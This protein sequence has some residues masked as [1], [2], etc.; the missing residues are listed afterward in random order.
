MASFLEVELFPH[1][2]PQMYSI[3]HF[4]NDNLNETKIGENKCQKGLDLWKKEAC[5]WFKARDVF[6]SW[7]KSLPNSETTTIKIKYRSSYFETHC[8]SDRIYGGSEIKYQRVPKENKNPVTSGN[9]I[10]LLAL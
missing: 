3:K 2:D 1:E 5:L 10:I 8:V 9:T 6:N 4:I 7:H